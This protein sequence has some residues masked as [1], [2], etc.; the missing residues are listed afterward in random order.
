MPSLQC[1]RGSSSGCRPLHRHCTSASR[2]Q[3]RWLLTGS[4][5]DAMRDAIPRP[6]SYSGVLVE[7]RLSGH[8]V[9]SHPNTDRSQRSTLNN[10]ELQS[11]NR[12]R[13]RKPP[14]ARLQA[15]CQQRKTNAVDTKRWRIRSA[16]RKRMA[17]LPLGTTHRGKV[18]GPTIRFHG[19]R[20]GS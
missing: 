5:H 10:Q 19:H 11:S 4:H 8:R 1:A 6:Q 3:C 13:C 16:H 15:Q 2:R 9:W 20:E 14:R 7:S 17:Q 12:G 18:A